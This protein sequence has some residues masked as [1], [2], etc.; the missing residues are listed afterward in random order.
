ML[1]AGNDSSRIK[2]LEGHE[3]MAATIFI[4]PTLGYIKV[5]I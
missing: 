2:T 3:L 5:D 4:A 1:D